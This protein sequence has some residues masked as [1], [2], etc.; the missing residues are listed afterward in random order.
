[1]K[2]LFAVAFVF[3]LAAGHSLFKML[4]DTMARSSS[5][6]AKY[7]PWGP[8]Q[9]AAAEFVNVRTHLIEHSR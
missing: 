4:R 9:D 7:A 6:K 5:E 1:M 2:I 8:V 3:A